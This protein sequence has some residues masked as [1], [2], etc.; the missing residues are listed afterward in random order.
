MF[1][2]K[3]PCSN[4]PFRKGQGHLFMLELERLTEIRNQSAFQCHKTVDY[5]DNGSSPGDR[6]QQCAGLMAVLSREN[7]D[8]QIMQIAQ[9]LGHLNASE[10]DPDHEA[11]ETW[12]D[13]L[14]AHNG[15]SL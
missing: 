9:R 10:L 4:C 3:R 13:V 15:S 14:D 5:H 12:A 2:L 6:P 11:Y 8:N 7:A 1:D